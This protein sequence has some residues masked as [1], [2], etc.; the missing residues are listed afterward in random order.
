MRAMVLVMRVVKSEVRRRHPDG[1]SL[2]QFFALAYLDRHAGASLT[3]VGDL[4]GLSAS[5][6]SKIVDQLTQR[7][8]ISRH[9]SADDRRRATLCLTPDGAATVARV[10]AVILAAVSARMADLPADACATIRT[11]MALLTTAFTAAPTHP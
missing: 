10:N 11:A 7:E 5:A 9:D 2:Q 3:D 6:T 8:L 1:L 4:L